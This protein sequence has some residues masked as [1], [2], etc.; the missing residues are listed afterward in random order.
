MVPSVNRLTGA[1]LSFH[2]RCGLRS[3]VM[4][5]REGRPRRLIDNMLESI[6]ELAS[7]AAGRPQRRK[8]SVTRALAGDWDKLGQDWRRAS[9][10]VIRRAKG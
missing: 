5:E 9:S 10:Q 1:V 2:I 8:Q 4:S 6:G 3:E 7:F